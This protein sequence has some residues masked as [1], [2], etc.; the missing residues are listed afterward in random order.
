[1][2]SV[3]GAAFLGLTIGCA[4]CHDHKYDPIL[5]KDHYRLQ[6]FFAN[7]S[8]GDGPLSIKDPVERRAYDEQ[9]ALWQEKTKVIRAEMEQISGASW[10]CKGEK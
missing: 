4:R 5:Q 2:T 8:F 10:D 3:T 1:M 9:E 6:A 7:T